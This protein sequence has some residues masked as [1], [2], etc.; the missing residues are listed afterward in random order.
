MR[1]LRSLKLNL[2]FLLIFGMALIAF[3]VGLSIC[4]K[5]NLEGYQT[6]WK[7]H[8][9]QLILQDLLLSPIS[10]F[11]VNTL[12]IKFIIENKKRSKSIRNL[13]KQLIDDGHYDARLILNGNL[14]QLEELEEKPSTN[15]AQVSQ[16]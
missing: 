11:I 3:I 15:T 13:T 4:S 1:I 2:H 10:S 14:P 6:P 5:Y 8:F 12:S 7:V 9:L 16:I